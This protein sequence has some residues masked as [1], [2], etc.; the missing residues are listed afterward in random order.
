MHRRRNRPPRAS[1]PPPVLRRGCCRG[2]GGNPDADWV[3]AV[4]ARP[5]PPDGFA[6]TFPSA[7]E[8]CEWLEALCHA[9]PRRSPRLARMCNTFGVASRDPHGNVYRQA[10]LRHQAARDA[11]VVVA[12]DPSG[13][14]W[15]GLV[16]GSG[17]DVGSGGSVAPPAIVD[18]VADGGWCDAAA[19]TLPRCDKPA[20]LD[21]W[22]REISACQ[23]AA[24]AAAA[25]GG[26][27]GGG[28]GSA[29]GSVATRR[30]RQRCKRRRRRSGDDSDAD[31]D[32]RPDGGLIEYNEGGADNPLATTA[33]ATPAA[34]GADG[35]ESVA[36]PSSSSPAAEV[37]PFTAAPPTAAGHHPWQ[38][39]WFQSNERVFTENRKLCPLISQFLDSIPNKCGDAFVSVLAPGAHIA[40]HQG[41]SNVKVT[42]HMGIDV[43]EDESDSATV[44]LQVGKE[45]R[46]WSV[47]QWFGFI[48]STPHEAWN[49]T[50]QPRTVLI[51]DVWH[52]AITNTEKWALD[53]CKRLAEAFDVQPA[54]RCLCCCIQ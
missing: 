52:P 21:A 10:V 9:A 39:I 44:R 40:L 4:L 32:P 1:P 29:R 41:P 34:A 15:P 35:I 50:S 5:P 31:D 22:C 37:A 48:D 28:G 18:V 17:D 51:V 42:C 46:R 53:G 8:V 2:R 26:G 24:A 27:G 36:T 43:P 25:A 54:A 12:Q 6:R 47:G 16:V 3:R 23:R 33:A 45:A 20:D 11:A 13:L 14:F 30:Q 38:A 49:R 19:A 7:G